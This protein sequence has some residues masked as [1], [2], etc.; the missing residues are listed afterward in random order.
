MIVSAQRVFSI[1]SIIDRHEILKS[2]G[3]HLHFSNRCS[4][5]Y[6]FEQYMDTIR[7]KCLLIRYI[8]V[9]LIAE[10]LPTWALGVIIGGGVLLLI[11]I[12][13]IVAFCIWF[14]CQKSSELIIQRVSVESTFNPKSEE[15]TTKERY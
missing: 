8:S 7:V 9:H 4:C 2:F 10:S 11:L 3:V 5:R 12:A 1:V 6:I 13:A 15:N 14:C